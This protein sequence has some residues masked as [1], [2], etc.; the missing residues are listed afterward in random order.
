MEQARKQNP[1][2]DQ[3]SNVAVPP[4]GSELPFY[5]ISP[6]MP[7]F[8]SLERGAYGSIHRW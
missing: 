2:Q 8:V 6:P 7:V 3:I 5:R 4:V 1:S